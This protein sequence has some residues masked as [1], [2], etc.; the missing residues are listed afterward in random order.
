LKC[1]DRSSH[2]PGKPSST[3]IG[4]AHSLVVL[5]VMASKLIWTNGISPPEINCP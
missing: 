4:S 5:E 2:I 1:L 3:R